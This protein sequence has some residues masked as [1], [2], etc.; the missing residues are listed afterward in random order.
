[1]V[2]NIVSQ[3]HEFF[4][5]YDEFS[6]FTRYASGCISELFLGFWLCLGFG[7]LFWWLSSSQKVGNIAQGLRRGCE[8][9]CYLVGILFVLFVRAGE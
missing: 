2:R 5:R 4:D 9:C 3:C 8:P 6:L 7:F 1:M